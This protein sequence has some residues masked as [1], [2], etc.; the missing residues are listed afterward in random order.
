DGLL[1][2]SSQMALFRILQECLENIVAHAR[3]RNVGVTL[4][5]D[6]SRVTLHVTDDGKGFD[7]MRNRMRRADSS[8]LSVM[9]E[10]ANMLG[11]FLSISSE[12]GRGT[13]VALTIPAAGMRQETST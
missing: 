5:N 11:G 13:D 4:T 12:Q 3:A 10:R 7:L 8:G 1:P 6:G 2:K 9:E